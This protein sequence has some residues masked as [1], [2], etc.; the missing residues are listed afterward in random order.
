VKS[1]FLAAVASGLLV[2]GCNV[3]VET[4][5]LKLAERTRFEVLWER[6]TRLPGNKAFALAGDPEGIN[7]TGLVYGLGSTDEARDKALDYC[8]EQRRVRRIDDPCLVFAVD[9]HVLA[10]RLPAREVDGA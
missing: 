10:A 5:G 4:I 2:A 3:G 8:E 7:A 6:Y 1:F 9:D